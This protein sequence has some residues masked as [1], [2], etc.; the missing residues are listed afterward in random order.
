MT[1]QTQPT[2]SGES[3]DR[4][5]LARIADVI[6]PGTSDLPAGREVGVHLDLLDR[7]LQ[8]DP[9]LTVAVVAFAARASEADQLSVDR[10]KSWGDEEFELVAFALTSAYY[11]SSDVRAMLG[12]PGQGRRPIALATPD[13]LCSD[14]LIAPVTER[15]DIYV[16]TPTHEGDHHANV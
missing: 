1:V 15:G 13:E 11:M 7:V 2:W 14:E 5:G 3:G 8:A 12:Y 6:L 9:R 16:P 10:L 4:E